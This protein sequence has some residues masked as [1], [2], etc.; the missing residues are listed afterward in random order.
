MNIGSVAKIVGLP[1]KTIR[2]YE[3]VGLLRPARAVNGYRHYSA[4]DVHRLR[5]IQWARSL[6]FSVK[7]CRQLLVLHASNGPD[8]VDVRAIAEAKLSEIDERLKELSRLRQ[9]LHRY[10]EQ[11][12]GNGRLEWPAIGGLFGKGA[13]SR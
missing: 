2:Y 12:W 3:E 11:C 4:S 13:M 7:E 10:M 6:G 9:S 5:F 8:S 1:A